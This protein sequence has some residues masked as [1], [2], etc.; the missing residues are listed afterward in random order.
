MKKCLLCLVTLLLTLGVFTACQTSSSDD[1]QSKARTVEEIK[2]SGKIVIGVFSDK[3]PFGYVD[4]N[5]DYQGYDVYFGNR[6]AKD[7]G[8][9][10]EYVPVEAASRVEYLVSNKVDIILANFTVTEERKEKVDFTLPYM[11]VALGVVSSD[12]A[13]I[14]DV[15]DLKGKTLIVCK[16]TTAETFFTENYPE[17]N[18]LKFDQYIEAYNAL[19]DGR[20]D[21]LS[22]DNTE[23]LAWAIENEGFS[24]GIES[25]GNIDTIA[26]A[27]QK[28]NQDLLDWLNNEIVELGKENFFHADYEETLAPVYGE[29]ANADSIVIEGGALE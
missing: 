1:S 18:L 26:G 13:L 21:A 25:L 14:T 19:L 12:K 20:G 28:G 22:T 23:V 27:V 7:L 10:V 2:Q 4:S 29:A 6:I 16:G 17:V 15:E 8:V 9:E 3:K 11:K 5:G 24:V